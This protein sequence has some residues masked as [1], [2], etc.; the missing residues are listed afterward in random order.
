MRIGEGSAELA[1]AAA[2][3]SILEVICLGDIVLVEQVEDGSG[4][5]LG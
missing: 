4:D 5:G 1:E 2:L 3:R